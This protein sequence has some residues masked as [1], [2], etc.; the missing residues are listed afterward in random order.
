MLVVLLILVVLL[1]LGYAP[2][3]ALNFPLFNFNGQVI[4]LWDVFIF[5]VMMYL[6]SALPRPFREIA[7]VLLVVWLLSIFG[8]IA[9]ANFSNIVV[10]A[11][12]VGLAAH[13]FSSR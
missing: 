8:I 9:I 1:L 13:I 3:A 7:S 6:L 5:F 10:I 2:I 4:D 11:L 12:I